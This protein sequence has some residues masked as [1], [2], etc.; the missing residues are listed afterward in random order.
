MSCLV[1]CITSVVT[2]AVTVVVEAVA[3]AVSA[4]RWMRVPCA[5]MRGGVWLVVGRSLIDA[6]DATAELSLN[7]R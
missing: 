7:V 4:I 3:V 1:C 5:I 6:D 2:V